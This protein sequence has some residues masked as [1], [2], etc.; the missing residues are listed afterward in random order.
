MAAFT[1]RTGGGLN[2]YIGVGRGQQH[3]N[4]DRRAVRSLHHDR[5]LVVGVREA[6]ENDRDVTHPD[7][8]IAVTKPGQQRRAGVEGRGKFQD[9]AGG[10]L[11]TDDM[12]VLGHRNNDRRAAATGLRELLRP[13]ERVFFAG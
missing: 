3:G 9:F 12:F 8:E 11:D 7:G 1:A 2:V 13:E 5:R 4:V 10:Y 6:F